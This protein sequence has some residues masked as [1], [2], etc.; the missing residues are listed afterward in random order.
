MFGSEDETGPEEREP[1]AAA[2]YMRRSRAVTVRR[3][4][5][6][7]SFQRVVRAALVAILILLPLGWGGRM[8]TVY[9]LN[10]PRFELNSPSDVTVVGNRYVSRE[11]IL[12][13]LGVPAQNAGSGINIFKM[14]LKNGERQIEN[15]P[16]ILSATVVRSYPHHLAVYVAERTPVAFVNAGGQIKMVDEYGVLLDTPA[17]SHFDFPIIRGLDFRADAAG[18][19]SQVA[20]YREF[21]RETSDKISRS[22]WTVSEVNL[23]DPG[24]LQALLVQGQETLLVRFGHTHFLERFENFLAVLPEL[25]KANGQIDSVDLRYNNQVVVNP[26]GQGSGNSPTTKAGPGSKAKKT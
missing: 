13:A 23:S 21:M 9:A 15:I 26:A 1:S 2:P 22:A 19:K 6:P 4:R 20:L 14:S 17:K 5:F 24:D 12:D 18:R 10:S 11:E 7:W 3:S 8:L 16:W 25:Q